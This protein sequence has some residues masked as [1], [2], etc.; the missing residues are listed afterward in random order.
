MSEVQRDPVASEILDSAITVHRQLGPGLLESSY[1]ACLE[2]ELLK[3][4]VRVERQV[5]VP[6]VYDGIKLDCGYRLDL[7]VDGGIIVEVKSVE[8]LT[9][10]HNAQVLTYLRLTGARQALLLNFNCLRLM[11]GLRSFLGQGKHVP[12]AGGTP[13][14]EG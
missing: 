7:L 3:R 5:Q 4:G 1:Q 11:D 12:P 10:L 13:Q 6:L 2:Y 8:V 14:D 9:P